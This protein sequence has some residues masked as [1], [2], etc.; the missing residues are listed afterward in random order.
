MDADIERA[1]AQWRHRGTSR[2]PWA[3]KPGPDQESVWDYPRPP[4]LEGDA[5]V[6]RVMHGRTVIGETQAAV[7]ILETASPPTFYIPR[8]DVDVGRLVESDGSSHCEWKGAATYWSLRADGSFAPQVGWSYEDPYPEFDTIRG[9]F[10]F[11]PAKLQC[12][13]GND[14]V[15]PQPGGFYGGWVTPEVVGPFKGDPGTGAW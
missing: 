12:F 3:I 5:R 10:S 6:V 8:Q 13:V 9:H 1:R 14:L 2:P 15:M 7:R 4:R 11:Y